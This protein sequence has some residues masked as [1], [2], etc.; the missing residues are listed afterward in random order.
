MS[1]SIETGARRD[2][3]TTGRASAAIKGTLWSLVSSFVPAALGFLVFLASSRVLSPAEFGIVAFAVS[4]ASVGVAIAPAGFREALIQRERISSAHLDT[5]FWLCLGAALVIYAVLCLAGPVIATAFGQPLLAL[6]IPLVAAR[7]IFDMAAAVPNALIVRTMAFK[8]LALRTTLA[9]LVTALIC[10]GLLWAGFGLWALA[11]SQLAGS[12]ASCAGA[13]IGARWLPGRRFNRSALRDLRAFGLFSNGNHFIT[14]INIDQL[15]IGALMGPGA[16]GI[17]SFARRI[18]QILTDL[19][20]GALNLVSYSLLASMQR[21]PA[22]LR[23]AYL[24]GTFAS[25]VVAFPV[26]SGLALVAGDLVP[27]AF[28]ASWVP[29]VPVVQAFCVLGLLTAIGI[30]QSSLIRSQGQADLWFY[31]ILGKQG[32][33]VLYIFLFS[34][35]GVMALTTSLVILNI[36]LWMPTLHMVVRLLGISLWAYLGSFALPVVATLAMC[37]CGWLVQHQLAGADPLLRLATTIGAAA[38]SYGAV[39]VLL[40]RPRLETLV[41]FVRRR[42]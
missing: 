37:G 12:V 32:V 10:L 3:L 16:L 14:T 4:I 33:T 17:Y 30:L 25:S 6:L 1:V 24:L 38:L 20:S 26:F 19:M 22:K 29:A 42:R 15:L 8:T 13:L 40:G 31:Y 21:E 35:W 23:E 34:S 11:V 36:I 9:S 27:M 39:I 18:F 7:V 2:H 41:G 28:G 5:V